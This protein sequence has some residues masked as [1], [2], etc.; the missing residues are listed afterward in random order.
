MADTFVV[1]ITNNTDSDL[2]VYSGSEVV[3][4]GP[5][6]YEFHHQFYTSL[7]ILAN[8]GERLSLKLSSPYD[9]ILC[10]KLDQAQ[11]GWE[12]N[13]NNSSARSLKSAK[14]KGKEGK[15]DFDDDAADEAVGEVKD[16]DGGTVNVTIDGDD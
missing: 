10:Y 11:L 16:G 8:G 9:Y 4:P 14:G 6:G 3:E 15:E 2:T 7:R 1:T 13:V 5:S 12:I